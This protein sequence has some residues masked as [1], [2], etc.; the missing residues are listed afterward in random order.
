MKT[1]GKMDPPKILLTI[2][3][4]TLGLIILQGVPTRAQTS[5]KSGAIAKRIEPDPEAFIELTA[6]LKQASREIAN[7]KERLDVLESRERVLQN[8]H[9]K[10]TEEMSRLRNL[11]QK[12]AALKA[13]DRQRNFKIEKVN[14]ITGGRPGPKDMV[15]SVNKFSI[16]WNQIEAIL[17]KL[18]EITHKLS[19]PKSKSN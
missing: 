15:V 19:L 18:D 13:G 4:F 12:S 11:T 3:I 17:D 14:R 8:K 5:S 1:L 9:R 10:M 2:V 7:L 6:Q 16:T